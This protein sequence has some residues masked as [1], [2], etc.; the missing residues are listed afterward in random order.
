MMNIRAPDSDDNDSTKCLLGLERFEDAIPPSTARGSDDPMPIEGPTTPPPPLESDDLES[1]E[2]D[3]TFDHTL[4]D[5]SSF[6]HQ[7]H[8]LPKNPLCRH[9]VM[10]KTKVSPARIRKISLSEQASITEAFQ[11]AIGP[12]IHVW[13]IH[14]LPYS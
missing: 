12:Q 10:F 3:A 13:P 6:A 14:T 5:A 11:V 4:N 8:H 1:E 7:V 9:C 2:V